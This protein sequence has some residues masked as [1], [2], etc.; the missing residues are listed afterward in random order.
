[1]Q[2][3]VLRLIRES[4]VA[5]PAHVESLLRADPAKVGGVSVNIRA[6]R[7][8]IPSIV[9]SLSPSLDSDTLSSSTTPAPLIFSGNSGM[10]FNFM[11]YLSDI[12]NLVGANAANSLMQDEA[13][14]HQQDVATLY[15]LQ[16]DLIF[17]RHFR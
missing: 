7:P 8:S 9:P 10:S 1:L 6:P 11:D 13:L 16:I 17:C 12:F 2:I 15:S 3:L 5:G 14:R 4:A